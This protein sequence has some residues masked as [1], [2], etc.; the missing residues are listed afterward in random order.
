MT[1]KPCFYCNNPIQG[2]NINNPKSRYVCLHCEA[3]RL[4][5][6]TEVCG[7]TRSLAGYVSMRLHAGSGYDRSQLCPE[8]VLKIWPEDG[9]CPALGIRLS[10]L[11]EGRT[12]SPSIDRIDSSK[13][14]T[15]D[16]IQV[17]S[18]LANRMKQNA[19]PDQ[20]KAFAE[21]VLSQEGTK[22]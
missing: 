12:H 19:T 5:M 22:Q 6:P 1:P 20:L 4:E 3:Q 14:Y 2:S 13:G 16:N 17:I 15:P 18:T 10:L 7:Q 8:D 11:K 21:W 9:M